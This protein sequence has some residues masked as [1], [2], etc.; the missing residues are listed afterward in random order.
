MPPVSPQS[1]TPCL[2]HRPPGACNAAAL[3]LDRGGIASVPGGV[4]EQVHK[5]APRVAHVLHQELGRL[6]VEGVKDPR[7]GF[8]TITEVRLTDDLRSCWVYV[9]IIGD[10]D[11]RAGSL[12]GLRGAAGYLRHALGKRLKLRYVPQLS[13]VHDTTLDQAQRLEQVLGAAF[14]GAT[15][16]PDADSLLPLPAA[17]T[18]REMPPVNLVEVPRRPAKGKKRRRRPLLRK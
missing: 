12:N 10:A 17:E 15:T 5:R 8:V 2:W 3:Q 9:S 16:A 18:G 13:F 11:S 1:C 6:L 4:Q 7:V 14:A